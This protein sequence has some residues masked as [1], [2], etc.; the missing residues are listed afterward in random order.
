METVAREARRR[1]AA[2]RKAKGEDLT[3]DDG[4]L[5]STSLITPAYV[6]SGSRMNRVWRLTS[7]STCHLTEEQEAEIK[8]L[9]DQNAANNVQAQNSL[10]LGVLAALFM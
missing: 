7:S 8:A 3:E 2:Q 1:T 10:D 6:Q 5:I 4:K 9:R